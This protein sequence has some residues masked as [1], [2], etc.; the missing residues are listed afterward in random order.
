MALN[1]TLRDMGLVAL[2]Q[3]PNA[4]R[5]S[6]R[7]TI[8]SEGAVARFYYDTGRL[9]H[10]EMGD[11]AGEEV[12][13][14]VVDW[15][16][17]EFR[18]EPDVE[19][20]ERT[21]E[22]DLHRTIMWALKERDERRKA[23]AAETGE[24]SMSQLMRELV[25][26]SERFVYACILSARGERKAASDIPADFED[27]LPAAVDSV[28]AFLQSYGDRPPG[29]MLVEDE[30][31]SLVMGP[32]GEGDFLLAAAGPGTRMGMLPLALSRLM[33]GLDSKG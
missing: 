25:E 7:V 31:F 19:S 3:F 18:F 17:G 30:R 20:G 4:G 14:Q 32:C 6:G 15:S 23:Q 27:S 22:K 1:G 2:L 9:V 16:D 11:L 10:A 8:E 28:T 21:I 29:R 33:E 24:D 5:R 12:L 13:V 26:D